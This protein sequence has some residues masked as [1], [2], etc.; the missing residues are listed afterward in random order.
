MACPEN[1]SF[2]VCAST[3]LCPGESQRLAWSARRC[4]CTSLSAHQ[5]AR[6]SSSGRLIDSPSLPAEGS[7]VTTRMR[8][9]WP[10]LASPS[11]VPGRP[12]VSR[13]GGPP[14]ESPIG[15]AWGCITLPCEML[16]HT[17]VSV[18][19]PIA[20]S[21]WSGG[22]QGGLLPI[23]VRRPTDCSVCTLT[24]VTQTREE[25]HAGTL[26]HTHMHTRSYDHGRI[27]AAWRA[28]TERDYG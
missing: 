25:A 19:T 5:V 28:D 20:S 2:H 24:S 14:V 15:A 4:R 1:E 6:A 10:I 7:T 11:P 27:L 18:L 13:E 12:P 16:T 22:V 26:G 17:S 9:S 21:C 3:G 23:R 8:T